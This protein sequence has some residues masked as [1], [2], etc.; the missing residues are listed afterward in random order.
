MYSQN[1][2]LMKELVL[3]NFHGPAPT[4]IHCRITLCK[5]IIIFQKKKKKSGFA[6]FRL[7]STDR[8]KYV[9]LKSELNLDNLK[10]KTYI[11][12]SF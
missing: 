6:I 3:V 4:T 8:Q 12:Q 7:D 11:T 2:E 9:V 10:F 5:R 1:V